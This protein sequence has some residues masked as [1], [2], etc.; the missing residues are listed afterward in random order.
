MKTRK[1]NKSNLFYIK[2]LYILD[3]TIVEKYFTCKDFFLARRINQYQLYVRNK[4][5]LKS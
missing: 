2:F 5:I 4:E 3:Y 1:I